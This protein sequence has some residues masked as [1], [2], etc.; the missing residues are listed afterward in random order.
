[1]TT[2]QPQ[3]SLRFTADGWQAK[4]LEPGCDWQFDS[5]TRQRALDNLIAHQQQGH[6]QPKLQRAC[7]C[8]QAKHF[9]GSGHPYGDATG[10]VQL[11]V[12]MMHG[13]WFC[14]TCWAD[15][16]PDAERI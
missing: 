11:N 13:E 16:W 1:M 2:P 6:Y 12:P 5:L 8:E 3:L 15:C 9:D 14:L 7:A 4:C 10:R